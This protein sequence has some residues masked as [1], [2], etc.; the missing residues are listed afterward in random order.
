MTVNSFRHSNNISTELMSARIRARIKAA[1][2]RFHANDNIA[3]FIHESELEILQAEV[4]EKILAV[5]ESMV[6]DLDNDHNTRD[7]A[8]RVAKMYMQELFYGRYQS[9]P[10]ITEFPNIERLNELIMVGPITVRSTCSH[11]FCPIIGKLWVGVMPNANSNLIGLSKYT[12]LIEWIMR[13]PQIQEEAISQIADLL[14]RKLLPDGLA[15][16]MEAEH[17]CMRWRGVKDSET[18]MINNIMRGSFLNNI[19]LRQEFLL[20]IHKN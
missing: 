16:V 2:I 17:F 15:L 11:H 19:N 9:P 13:R 10:S 20:L 5:L 14:M 4:Q 1:G 6:I 12:R 3:D 7:T 18:K 8:K